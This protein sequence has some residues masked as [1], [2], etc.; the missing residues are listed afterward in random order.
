MTNTEKERIIS[1]KNQGMSVSKIAETIGIPAGTIKTF[2]RRTE[3]KRKESTEG[4]AEGQV[5][6]SLAEASAEADAEATVKADAEAQAESKGEDATSE[7]QA[8][9]LQKV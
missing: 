5:T 1:L 3:I 2:L 4:V 9:E 8:E 6:A 7:A